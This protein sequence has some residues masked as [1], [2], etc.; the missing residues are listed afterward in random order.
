MKPMDKWDRQALANMLADNLLCVKKRPGVF[1]EYTA[2][3]LDE[4][5]L[6]ALKAHAKTCPHCKPL[7]KAANQKIKEDQAR[8]RQ[9]MMK[10]L[11]ARL[12]QD[13]ACPQP[14]LRWAAAPE[15][16]TCKA[17]ALG[18]I[19]DPTK[20]IGALFECTAHV[21]THEHD[22][23][24]FDIWCL[25]SRQHPDGTTTQGPLSLMEEKFFD[26]LFRMCPALNA[27][28]LDRRYIKV[29]TS[30]RVIETADSLALAIIMAIVLAFEKPDRVPPALYSAG[31]EMDGTLKPVDGLA[32]KI[33]A[34]I[35]AG[36]KHFIFSKQ[37]E[38]EVPAR[39][40]KGR[41]F[42]FFNHLQEVFA[43][44]NI[45]G[46]VPE[47]KPKPKATA[48]PVT[49]GTKTEPFDTPPS[50]QTTSAIYPGSE[51][52]A[53]CQRIDPVSVPSAEL[54][55]HLAFFEQ[56]CQTGGFKRNV[57]AAFIYG[58]SQKICGILPRAH[59]SFVSA[60]EPYELNANYHKMAALLDGRYFGAV[61]DQTGHITALCRTDI[62]LTGN[63]DL[64]PLLSGIYKRYALI[65][66]LTM[67]LVYFIPPFGNRLHI[68]YK[69]EQ[70]GKYA[71]GRWQTADYGKVLAELREIAAS[72]KIS[73]PALEKTLKTALIMAEEEMGGAFA[74]LE[75]PSAHADL[76]DSQLDNRFELTLQPLDFTA[77]PESE[78]AV[79]AKTDGALIIDHS[80]TLQACQ[81][82]FNTRID[83]TGGQSIRSQYCQAFS[84]QTGALVVVA[85]RLGEVRVYLE[86][87][88]IARI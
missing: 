60:A 88:I 21:S 13:Y 79:L 64:S 30:E 81:V 78:I 47:H 48:A 45:K 4:T 82:F 61:I 17:K 55:K 16:E 67:A 2:G 44:F 11:H 73:R 68:F 77:L 36:I 85:S 53:I 8:T 39:Y 19:V 3:D 69:G 38:K 54:K 33:E 62:D 31:L 28:N 74:F 46:L 84:L 12:E 6:K 56:L 80:G 43:H 83:C 50:H 63:Q 5:E 22:R 57:S 23:P 86:G 71:N 27:Y 14:I 10:H 41:R 76:W 75:N 59:F 1:D 29:D 58:D 24:Q 87:E 35:K 26:G 52:E 40:R 34:G 66:L 72:R 65:S 37:D 20:T 70:I 15:I 32:A 25:E 7:L 18:V 9:T 42:H 49:T 51:I